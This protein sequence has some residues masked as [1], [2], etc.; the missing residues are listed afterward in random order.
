[1][2]I[3]FRPS[4]RYVTAHIIVDALP[5]RDAYDKLFSQ[6]ILPIAIIISMVI[7]L[8]TSRLRDIPTLLALL[9][10]GLFVF[11]ICITA[12]KGEN[13]RMKIFLE[14]VFYVLIATQGYRLV[15]RMWQFVRS[16]SSSQL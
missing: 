14:P 15:S 9:L 6:P 1:M 12:E 10:P 8:F 2:E 11:A 13:M 16:A 3:Y 4:S 5:W 7:A